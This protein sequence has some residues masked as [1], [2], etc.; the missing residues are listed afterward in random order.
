MSESDAV[1]ARSA[2]TAIIADD[3]AFARHVI[4]DALQNAGIVVIA[5]ARN[6]R[7]AVELALYHRPDVVVMDMVMPEVDGIIATRRIVKELPDQIVVILTGADEDEELGLQALRAGATGYLSKDLDIDALPRALE[8]ART[9]EAVLSR[10]MTRRLIEH[11]RRIP[12]GV[13]GMRPVR[14]PLTAREWE[15]IDLLRGGRSTDEIAAD[16]VLSTETVRSH[17]KNILRKLDVRSR[18]QAV[19]AADQMRSAPPGDAPS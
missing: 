9:G 17:V 2:L 8:G 12:D 5:E 13:A 16:L 18:A 6:G 14:S 4:R 3:D 7:E 19:A 15:V 1:R 10:R 11:V